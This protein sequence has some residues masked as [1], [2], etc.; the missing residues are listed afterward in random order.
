MFCLTLSIIY[1]TLRHSFLVG[2]W[3]LL[4]RL[5]SLRKTISFYLILVIAVPPQVWAQAASSASPVPTSPSQLPS[6]PIS[7]PQTTR[8]Q[9]RWAGHKAA[10]LA[11]AILRTRAPHLIKLKKVDYF[12][13]LAPYSQ[14]KVD[15]ELVKKTSVEL[16][17][18]LD[19]GLSEMQKS[20]LA[21]FQLKG[22]TLVNLMKVEP[23]TGLQ[24][25]IGDSLDA[26][27][28][29][30]PLDKIFADPTQVTGAKNTPEK[31]DASVEIAASI[32]Q[33]EEMGL[34]FFEPFFVE[35]S[36]KRD[37]S[38][39][40]TNAEVSRWMA[41]LKMILD[42]RALLASQMN[43]E[44][45]PPEFVIPKGPD[46]G[47]A[48]RV[49]INDK[50]VMQDRA[51]ELLLANQMMSAT[52]LPALLP[53]F[54]ECSAK[55]KECGVEANGDFGNALCFCAGSEPTK[56]KLE[57][58]ILKGVAAKLGP[59]G[60]YAKVEHGA[61]LN[62]E[63]LLAIQSLIMELASISSLLPAA[64]KPA[65]LVDL[66]PQACQ[67]SDDLSEH[68]KIFKEFSSH[69]F[70][71][72]WL[73]RLQAASQEYE[74]AVRVG[75]KA[76]ATPQ[77]A[78]FYKKAQSLLREWIETVYAEENQ[79]F[80]EQ[81]A[82]AEK[83]GQVVTDEAPPLVLKTIQMVDAFP[84][85]DRLLDGGDRASG[86]ETFAE[87]FGRLISVWGALVPWEFEKLS[88]ESFEK[89]DAL[90]QEM[91][92]QAYESSLL[93]ALQGYGYALF[94]Y[95]ETVLGRASQVWESQI[96]AKWQTLLSSHHPDA[97]VAQE[98]DKIAVDVTKDLLSSPA[99]AEKYNPE[100]MTDEA[101]RSYVRL[102]GPH[103]AEAFIANQVEE[104]MGT[105]VGG[106]SAVADVLPAGAW[107]PENYFYK[108]SKIKDVSEAP[109]AFQI[110]NGSGHDKRWYELFVSTLHPEQPGDYENLKSGLKIM[111]AESLPAL[112]RRLTR[113]FL[114]M[115]SKQDPKQAAWVLSHFSDFSSLAKGS[116]PQAKAVALLE[117][118]GEMEKQ[119][120]AKSLA[121]VESA[122][123]HASEVVGRYF[124]GGANIGAIAN[125]VLKKFVETLEAKDSRDRG[126]VQ[127]QR[128]AAYSKVLAWLGDTANRRAFFEARTRLATSIFDYHL[129]TLLELR[130]AS[131]ARDTDALLQDRLEGLRDQQILIPGLDLTNASAQLVG[132]YERAQRLLKA[133]EVRNEAA[134]LWQKT[135]DEENLE[136][137]RFD[138]FCSADFARCETWFKN[139]SKLFEVQNLSSLYE[140]RIKNATQ[141][142]LNNF[143]IRFGKNGPLYEGSSK[144]AT[145]DEVMLK[146]VT[147]RLSQSW[148]GYASDRYDDKGK[149]IL[150]PEYEAVKP[151]IESLL[152]D[153][154]EMAHKEGSD[155]AALATVPSRLAQISEEL[156]LFPKWEERLRAQLKQVSA[157][158]SSGKVEELVK[159]QG[160]ARRLFYE[161]AKELLDYTREFSGQTIRAELIQEVAHLTLPSFSRF[162]AEVSQSVQ[163]L[164]RGEADA[165]HA[166]GG[167]E[168]RR[169]ELR[170]IVW[171]LEQK[172]EK[173]GKNEADISKKSLL[174]E[175]RQLE[176]HEIPKLKRQIHDE[177]IF[178]TLVKTYLPDEVAK[179]ALAD[180]TT[181]LWDSFL[182]RQFLDSS[183]DGRG[184][185]M[186]FPM[187]TVVQDLN[188][189]A[190]NLE[191]SLQ[192]D[193]A[194]AKKFTEAVGTYFGAWL[195]DANSKKAINKTFEQ[196][197]ELQRDYLVELSELEKEDPE[198]YHS[199]FSVFSNAPESESIVS[200][201]GFLKGSRYL[202]LT[203]IVER[204]HRIWYAAKGTTQGFSE[205]LNEAQHDVNKTLFVPQ[206]VNLLLVVFRKRVED[207]RAVVHALERGTDS[208]EFENLEALVSGQR[209]QQ[210]LL[211]L[212]YQ[213]RRAKGSSEGFVSWVDSLDADSASDPQLNARY[214]PL[215]TNFPSGETFAATVAARADNLLA[216]LGKGADSSA[217]ALPME[218][219]NDYSRFVALVTDVLYAPNSAFAPYVA[220]GEKTLWVTV[221]PVSGISAAIPSAEAIALDAQKGGFGTPAEVQYAT[222]SLLRLL[223]L[224][225]MDKAALSQLLNTFL[226]SALKIEIPDF[227]TAQE[228][229]EWVNS[230][231]A[232]ARSSLFSGLEQQL[233]TKILLGGTVP[234]PL[235]AAFESDSG[236]A[237]VLTHQE[238]VNEFFGLLSIWNELK[239]A[240]DFTP[241]AAAP[242]EGVADS[243]PVQ[244]PPV[245]TGMDALALRIVRSFLANTSYRLQ[246]GG[247]VAGGSNG[248]SL[249]RNES[250]NVF[251]ALFQTDRARAF[252]LVEDISRI[253]VK[254]AARQS[255]QANIQAIQSLAQSAQLG[256]DQA[257][258]S[259]QAELPFSG[260][261]FPA[262][263][264][265]SPTVLEAAVDMYLKHFSFRG[266]QTY[267]QDAFVTA[268]WAGRYYSALS[269][270]A[271]PMGA[272]FE[273][274]VPKWTLGVASQEQSRFEE[275]VNRIAAHP[276]AEQV[277]AK[278]KA[279]E[280]KQL[281]KHIWS[282]HKTLSD[283]V[284]SSGM[285]QVKGLMAVADTNSRFKDH[286][287]TYP[288]FVMLLDWNLN[289]HAAPYQ[290]RA[291]TVLPFEDAI[292]ARFMGELVDLLG[293]DTKSFVGWE[294]LLKRRGT[295][296]QFAAIARGKKNILVGVNEWRFLS[297]GVESD[298]VGKNLVGNRVYDY[299]PIPVVSE[300]ERGL[301]QFQTE[302]QSTV[303]NFARYVESKK[304]VEVEAFNRIHESPSDL[305]N[306]GVKLFESEQRRPLYQNLI[307]LQG[308][309]HGERDVQEAKARISPKYDRAAAK[310][311]KE[312]NRASEVG[313]FGHGLTI[314][315]DKAKLV[316]QRLKLSGVFPVPT[317]AEIQ[318][319][320][321]A[322]EKL[323][324]FR[325]RLSE[326][327][328]AQDS[329]ALLRAYV[330][331]LDPKAGKQRVDAIVKSAQGTFGEAR[332][333]ALYLAMEFTHAR[334]FGGKSAEDVQRTSKILSQT[335]RV[336]V[337]EMQKFE[338]QSALA[339]V[340]SNNQS[341]LEKLC[342]P[343]TAAKLEAV[344][345]NEDLDEVETLLKDT[346]IAY[347]TGLHKY[348]YFDSGFVQDGE[349]SETRRRVN[350]IVHKMSTYRKTLNGIGT[351]MNYALGAGLFLT[352]FGKQIPGVSTFGRLAMRSSFG[353]YGMMAASGLIL[354]Y[355]ALDVGED[356][357][358]LERLF[359]GDELEMLRKV[360]ETQFRGHL[361][362]RRD[363]HVAQLDDA[364]VAGKVDAHTVMPMIRGAGHA[365]MAAMTLSM[366]A[367]AARAAVGGIRGAFQA[368]SRMVLNRELP[369]AYQYNAKAP[370]WA[371]RMLV[372]SYGKMGLEQK[373]SHEA[374]V[375]GLDPKQVLAM[376]EA[377]AHLLMEEA[378]FQKA[379]SQ[380]AGQRGA[381][382]RGAPEMAKAI[383]PSERAAENMRQGIDAE[384]RAIASQ[385]YVHPVTGQRLALPKL[386]NSDRFKLMAQEMLDAQDQ[387]VDRIKFLKQLQTKLK[388]PQAHYTVS[389]MSRWLVN[390]GNAYY[391]NTP[392]WKSLAGVSFLPSETAR[393]VASLQRTA[394]AR[395]AAEK[396]VSIRW[397][398]RWR[399]SPT[400]MRVF[401][402]VAE[403]FGIKPLDLLN[404]TYQKNN[405]Y[406]SLF[407]EHLSEKLM[408]RIGILE[409]ES[410]PR[411]QL[412]RSAQ[413][414]LSALQVGGF[415]PNEKLFS[416][417]AETSTV[418]SDR[419]LVRHCMTDATAQSAL[420]ERGQRNL[421][422]RGANEEAAGFETESFG[423]AI[424]SP[425]VA[426]ADEVLVEGPSFVP[427]AEGIILSKDLKTEDKILDYIEQVLTE[428]RASAGQALRF[429]PESR[430]WLLARVEAADAN[431]ASGVKYF[432]LLDRRLSSA[433]IEGLIRTLK[434]R[435]QMTPVQEEM[436]RNTMAYLAALEMY[437]ENAAQVDVFA[438]FAI[439]AMKGVNTDRPL[440]LATKA[441]DALY[442]SAPL[443]DGKSL[444]VAISKLRALTADVGVEPI[445]QDVAQ[446]RLSRMGKV[447]AELSKKTAENSGLNHKRAFAR[448]AEL[449]KLHSQLSQVRD[450]DSALS[451]AATFG[452]KPFAG[453]DVVL[454][455][456]LNAGAN[457][458]PELRSTVDKILERAVSSESLVG[459]RM[460][461]EREGGKAWSK[462]IAESF[463][464]ALAYTRAVEVAK[465]EVAHSG[466]QQINKAR[467]QWVSDLYLK[468]FEVVGVDM[469]VANQVAT[470]LFQKN[471]L[472]GVKAYQQLLGLDARVDLKAIEA[473]ISL[474]KGKF[475]ELKGL[476]TFASFEADAELAMSRL[477]AA[478]SALKFESGSDLGFSSAWNA[479]VQSEEAKATGLAE[480]L[481]RGT[482]TATT[483]EIQRALQELRLKVLSEIASEKLPV[484]AWDSLSRGSELL[485]SRLLLK[486]MEADRVVGQQELE[487]IA[488]A[489]YGF[490]RPVQHALNQNEA[491]A[492]LSEFFTQK[493]VRVEPGALKRLQ[494]VQELSKKIS[495]GEVQ[496]GKLWV[497]VNAAFDTLRAAASIE[498]NFER[499]IIKSTDSLM[500]PW[501]LLTQEP[502]LNNL[503][504]FQFATASQEGAQGGRILHVLLSETPNPEVEEAVMK[505]LRKTVEQHR[506]SLVLENNARRLRG[507]RPVETLS[508]VDEMYR[509]LMDRKRWAEAQEE[510][511][512][513]IILERAEGRLGRAI[514]G[515]KYRG[516]FGSF[517]RPEAG[518]EL[519]LFG[520]QFPMGPEAQPGL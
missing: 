30:T 472:R 36:R 439:E 323:V 126:F 177:L 322:R 485:R 165:M 210:A 489:L 158:I 312:R 208:R 345:T 46:A 180:S 314:D 175:L 131:N 72:W 511:A 470:R 182:K 410:G 476:P 52:Q 123:D 224:P 390:G 484:S 88:F 109:A 318:S 89:R 66:L 35:L 378:Q 47:P 67:A 481:A 483:E 341:F 169:L 435:G 363:K 384:I 200:F 388:G 242:A 225:K 471:S 235:V 246:A 201:L 317:V 337:E 426:L 13:A 24:P 438:R 107:N 228:K 429:S 295:P 326:V 375:L 114:K 181:A 316:A 167:L 31:I 74:A 382:V 358:G 348:L 467:V 343:V 347:S 507:E 278:L 143:L 355:F 516:E 300:S 34:A 196:T 93:N 456:Q 366:L 407:E 144:V 45:K 359:S 18:A 490:N 331:E 127:A 51:G 211:A 198:L 268:A 400:G 423:E 468:L 340:V 254:E 339:I 293:I 277:Y 218:L 350:S 157:A 367:P 237:R 250:V 178:G 111:A 83:A 256:L 376:P 415:S 494:N 7:A 121:L 520:G 352:I 272:S 32:A 226:L 230:L 174:V 497:P 301:L 285:Q 265:S 55:K 113:L 116:N 315:E 482:E 159:A 81:K 244:A 270:G 420:F 172:G 12:T 115:D 402:D 406:A 73:Q 240:F 447:L 238:W 320:A 259:L 217:K 164:A 253:S 377:E 241:P 10:R 266:L 276:E 150:V 262:A 370:W 319:L 440:V 453:S 50:R 515:D 190:R 221:P 519:D 103:A 486:F 56:G 307:S 162:Q 450:F 23:E 503:Q 128:K 436:Y 401:R 332:D 506:A 446:E 356:L 408:G 342:N 387:A 372:S 513:T 365:W 417:L 179:L 239:D 62:A 136:R 287:E 360:A 37:D 432:G 379:L 385:N 433:D 249:D 17:E 85:A 33:T 418:T 142:L 22:E 151:R 328:T 487:A 100:K 368:V 176:N 94:S 509:S 281:S 90:V 431:V 324:D 63:R 303:G 353:R 501:E 394:T 197:L 39:P 42:F 79:K 475:S 203:Q 87:T 69:Q 251:R 510:T 173:P 428:K 364:R 449:R 444:E 334:V 77:N 258:P 21:L 41:W 124:Q 502:L 25:P 183:V 477:E 284:K 298:W 234:A 346:S 496:A 499:E 4:M 57:E 344:K 427:S 78:A 310:A 184:E 125:I 64:A 493:G 129:R 362:L 448:L 82:E 404:A 257:A 274:Y 297:T 419:A 132:A 98:L 205:W 48:Q 396:M 392:L 473:R 414:L 130:N 464:Y 373:L 357:F 381:A 505:L 212:E 479:F 361:P 374:R 335:D 425:E 38:L 296:Q 214:A 304:S 321:A 171:E 133:G 517:E 273:A 389:D 231:S 299:K 155:E 168:E 395:Q 478:Q 154:S 209:V 27:C 189:V 308:Q 188:A 92:R 220:S 463:R 283:F 106:L 153:V 16:I 412:K 403:E 138:K 233:R 504:A 294:T 28:M 20:L 166:L 2:F 185:P 58:K 306:K 459:L 216:R 120:N 279:T 160:A 223:M 454:A 141:D 437:G 134:V 443:A 354:G 86:A 44:T 11:D 40:L 112:K 60:K 386:G 110:E 91:V 514:Y 65:N 269:F 213:W 95:D 222:N 488:K 76:V 371:R 152:K 43:V 442:G 430:K 413:E 187:R 349:G 338:V 282:N 192:V 15:S 68:V 469:G 288:H 53:H 292:Q 199:L 261:F 170:D 149:E 498:M 207:K 291:A 9:A 161:E 455:R 75:A 248:A 99:F 135:L 5:V 105:H 137:K 495:S 518:S 421:S 229:V 441:F 330:Q 49:A 19:A 101:L 393:L 280:D 14:C 391:T 466:A 457:V 255:Y 351:T 327:T 163:A 480:L 156:Q 289:E 102:V 271:D 227:K 219:R 264:P 195:G 508:Q 422:K 305:L 191:T 194:T 1:S 311:S 29:P 147:N 325:K 140:L 434:S 122:E 399:N 336:Y 275:W 6:A 118:L 491:A 286:Q 445:L 309:M 80:A 451:A 260:L 215:G 193:A 397:L 84:F 465:A 54:V 460:Q 206:N 263:E 411:E 71:E 512:Q 461:L 243:A 424:A 398:L 96:R 117:A 405:E 452:K 61:Y 313:A 97:P 145:S 146:Q 202:G 232:S 416:L 383:F 329:A 302:G 108:N 380:T 119:G 462:D 245:E 290:P 247:W 26:A 186:E 267:G 139:A 204:F 500:L 409:K 8:D 492:F 458:A 333:R 236:T 59:E 70:R 104:F 148:V 369:L 3:G 474:L 252:E